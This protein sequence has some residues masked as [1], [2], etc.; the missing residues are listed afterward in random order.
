MNR[1]AISATQATIAPALVIE[2]TVSGIVQSPLLDSVKTD[3]LS[4]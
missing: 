3:R 4:I 1:A 2:K